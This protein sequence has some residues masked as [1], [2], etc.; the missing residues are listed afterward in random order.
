MFLFG[1]SAVGLLAASWT[2]NPALAFAS[3]FVSH[4]FADAVPHGDEDLGVWTKQGNEVF[5]LALL[6]FLDLAVLSLVFA[7]LWRS[8]GWHWS[9][10][11]AVAGACLPDFMWGAELALRRKL[12]GPFGDFHKRNHNRWKVRV[13]AWYGVPLQL[14]FSLALWWLIVSRF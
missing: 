6:M 9:H 12:F 11:A 2:G 7:V 10:V 5:R 4:Y 14:A 1:H 13:P 3:G 8:T